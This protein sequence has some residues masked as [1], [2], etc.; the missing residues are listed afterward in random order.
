MNVKEEVI[1]GIEDTFALAIDDEVS[2]TLRTLVSSNLNGITGVNIPVYSDSNYRAHV[3]GVYERELARDKNIKPGDLK[4]VI[5]DGPP[6]V[7]PA[8]KVIVA[9]VTYQIVGV[10][11]LYEGKLVTLFLRMEG[12]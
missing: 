2:L 1:K 7:D 8:A 10:R 3:G 6:K 11:T 5:L 4:A 12:A 9:E